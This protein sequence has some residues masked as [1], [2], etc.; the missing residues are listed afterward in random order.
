MYLNTNAKYYNSVTLISRSPRIGTR[1][2]DRYMCLITITVFDQ[3]MPDFGPRDPRA[4]ASQNRDEEAPCEKKNVP[5]H[6]PNVTFPGS[7]M[8][9]ISVFH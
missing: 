5:A 8:I 7:K 1:E 2:F 6:P 9:A 3:R 4:N